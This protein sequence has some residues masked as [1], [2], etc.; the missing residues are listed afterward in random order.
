MTEQSGRNRTCFSGDGTLMDRDNLI[1]SAIRKEVSRRRLS[2]AEVARATGIPER[3][4]RRILDER[5]NTT[6]KTA[7]TL[8]RWLGLTVKKK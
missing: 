4:C 2:P 3:T 7:D 8:L 5:R 6:I 1:W